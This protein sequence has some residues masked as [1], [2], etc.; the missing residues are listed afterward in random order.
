MSD[1]KLNSRDE[2]L[3]RTM[4]EYRAHRRCVM[5][6]TIY[7]EYH[8]MPGEEYPAFLDYCIGH[9]EKE[10]EV[11]S[12]RVLCAKL[13]YWQCRHNARQM[14]DLEN[15]FGEMMKRKKSTGLIKA[16]DSVMEKIDRWK[17][18]FGE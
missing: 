11:P 17:V 3:A 1:N 8:F 13:A 9:M 10:D 16:R 14:E 12:V 5:L 18:L 15:R 7:N 6:A 4:K 2:F